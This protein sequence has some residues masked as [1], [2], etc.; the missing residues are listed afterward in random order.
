MQ[1]RFKSRVYQVFSNQIL[2]I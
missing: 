1:N 2:V